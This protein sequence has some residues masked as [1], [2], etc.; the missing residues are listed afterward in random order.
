MQIEM[1]TT[2]R[3]ARYTKPKCKFLF[4]HFS[5]R[6]LMITWRGV[7]DLFLSETNNNNAICCKSNFTCVFLYPPPIFLYYYFILFF[8]SIQRNNNNNFCFILL[9]KLRTSIDCLLLPARA[10]CFIIYI[11]KWKE[12]STKTTFFLTTAM[13]LIKLHWKRREEKEKISKGVWSIESKKQPWRLWS[14]LLPN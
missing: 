11:T 4:F 14:L 9:D 13:I 8:S 7:I 2:K 5:N 10:W 3:H 12:K 1:P 6:N